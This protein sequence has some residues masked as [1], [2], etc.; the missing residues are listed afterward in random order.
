MEGSEWEELYFRFREMSKAAGAKK[1]SESQ[2]A[3][4]LCAMK[5]AKDSE[6][7]FYDPAHK[8]NILGRSQTRQKWWREH[9]EDY[10]STGQ[11]SEVFGE[12][13]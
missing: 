8:D 4:A 3:K 1:P 12:P 7:D 11:S 9:L 10:R 5:A 2:R 6:E 13:S